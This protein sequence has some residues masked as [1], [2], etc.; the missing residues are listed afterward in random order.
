MQQ[1]FGVDVDA[2]DSPYVIDYLACA[3][4]GESPPGP[5][6]QGDVIS[7]ELEYRDLLPADEDTVRA[8]LKGVA[9]VLERSDQVGDVA[10]R[11]PAVFWGLLGGRDAISFAHWD[12]LAEDLLN[13]VREFERRRNRHA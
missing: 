7:I 5:S 9:S 2:L 13:A 6:T 8:L 11:L 1:V 3:H 10:H 4:R 12:W